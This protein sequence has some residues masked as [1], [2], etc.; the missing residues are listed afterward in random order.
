MANF[1][2]EPETN[3]M[4]KILAILLFLNFMYGY[5]Q[6]YQKIINPLKTWT[7]AEWGYNFGTGNI[8]RNT[9]YA[10]IEDDTILDG[11][12]YNK[13]I[14]SED[15]EFTDLYD[16]IDFIR[17]DTIEKKVY[18]YKEYQEKLRYDFSASIFSD[19]LRIDPS[20]ICSG[21]F[22]IIESI[23]YVSINGINHKRYTFKDPVWDKIWIEG[24]GSMF[25]IVETPCVYDIGNIFLCLGLNNNIVYMNPEYNTCYMETSLVNDLQINNSPFKIVNEKDYLKIEIENGKFC[26]CQIQILTLA[27]TIINSFYINQ[28]S[29]SINKKEFNKGMYL[30]RGIKEHSII[31]VNKILIE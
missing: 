18:V 11:K 21:D 28:N 6:Q 15:I 22:V 8:D 17:E 7:I 3:I 31:G 4:K 26:G 16:R 29:F 1:I 24:I 2:T 27:G 19:T 23:D 14:Y 12:E 10:R 13:I 25:H 9:I 20:Y 5:C 30:I